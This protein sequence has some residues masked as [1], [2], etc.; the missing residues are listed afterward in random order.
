M[1]FLFSFLKNN[2]VKIFLL[3]FLFFPLWQS[4]MI[5]STVSFAD[6]D[7]KNRQINTII[8]ISKSQLRQGNI[9]FLST[10]NSSV[11]QNITHL[12]KSIYPFEAKDVPGFET[13]LTKVLNSHCSLGQ[14]QVA[15]VYYFIWTQDTSQTTMDLSSAVRDLNFFFTFQTIMPYEG[16]SAY[17]ID[18]ILRLLPKEE[19]INRY[20]EV[21]RISGNE[22]AMVVM[23]ADHFSPWIGSVNTGRII[24]LASDPVRTST[25]S[26][27]V[28]KDM[29]PMISFDV[30]WMSRFKNGFTWTFMNQD[31]A[32]YRQDAQIIKD[33]NGIVLVDQNAKLGSPALN[34]LRDCDNGK[35]LIVSQ[36]FRQMC[37]K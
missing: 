16:D 32:A 7:A 10:R 25:T 37:L 6:D 26:N 33:K 22:T 11:S 23:E 24:W 8:Q 28:V 14:D 5:S 19:I 30:F 36:I 4:I 31:T 15:P 1:T 3:V 27:F 21:N 18:K 34:Y 20:C 17:A 9:V 35:K 13:Q 2:V 12:E 29:P